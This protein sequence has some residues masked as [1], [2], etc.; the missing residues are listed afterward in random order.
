MSNKRKILLVTQY[1]YPENFKSNDIAFELVRRGHIVDALVG[2]P[3]YPE[4]K[5][6]PGYGIFRKRIETL[7]GVTVY[8]A[9][10]TPRG[11]SATG[12]GLTINYLTYAIFASIWAIF[13]S[14]FKK[15][16]DIIIVHQPSPI[17]QALPAVILS[18][19]KNTPIYLW[20]LDLWPNV[21]YYNLKSNF[22]K[23]IVEKISN[24]IYY[25]SEKILISSKGFRKIIEEYIGLNDRII[26]FPNWVDDLQEMPVLPIP[27]LPDGYRIMMAG[28]LGQTQ[29]LDVVM[30]LVVSLKDVDVLKW[31][32]IGD[33][34]RKKWLEEFVSNNK[35]ENKVY[36]LGRFPFNYIPSFYKQADAML[37]T[38]LTNKPHLH[39]TIPSRF[40]S[41]ISSGK[42][43]LA[44]AGKG[45]KELIEEID[46]GYAIDNDSIEEMASYIRDTVLKN[47]VKFA[48]KGDNG[49][50]YYIS[51]FTTNICMDNL[52]N[53]ISNNQ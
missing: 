47:K 37:L 2:I 31:I 38:L 1:F 6:Y 21:A 49:R 10:Q 34:S 33:G 30:N 20:V 13:F 36:I 48:R 43:I 22:S 46:C 8:R 51:Q 23:K 45:V 11:R 5:Y 53:I 3:N 19:M 40:Q 50:E 29:K 52:E 25:N 14:V 26:Y 27:E 16:Y 24:V 9:F 15:K 18:K 39:A 12:L 7:N 4:G 32:F 42:P 44:M 17:T 41:Y 28:N 35:L